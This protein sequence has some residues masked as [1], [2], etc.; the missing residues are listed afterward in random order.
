MT[1]G[2]WK[3]YFNTLSSNKKILQKLDNICWTKRIK[4]KEITDF[5]RALNNTEQGK[6]EYRQLANE[7]L[8]QVKY[9]Y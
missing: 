9:I 5:M 4:E 8:E 3:V 1:P 6:I 2:N 7:L